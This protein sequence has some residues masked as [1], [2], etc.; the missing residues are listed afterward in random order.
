MLR[1]IHA[2]VQHTNDQDAERILLEENA[3]AAPATSFFMT[4][5]RAVR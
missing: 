3:V 4:S 1:M 2:I 5:D